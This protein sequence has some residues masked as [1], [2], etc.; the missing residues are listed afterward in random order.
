MPTEIE[1]ATYAADMKAQ[2]DT[3]AKRLLG[4][5]EILAR[6][7]INTIKEF[8]DM[9]PEDVAKLIE[10]EIAIGQVPADPGLTNAADTVSEEG[11][12]GQRI[13]GMNT[14]N[15]EI[16]EGL[17]RFD[18]I[19]Y[20]RMKDGVSQV[21]INVEIQKN[22][23]S[24]YD[25]LNRAIFY[26]CR[27]ISSQKERDFVNTN[28][29][30]I[31][32]VFSIWICMNTKE[33]SMNYIHLVNDTLLGSHEC[34]GNLDLINIILVSLAEELPSQD[35][36]LY[37]HRFLGTLLSDSLVPV[38]KLS[39][40]ETEFG[41]KTSS[42]EK[43]VNTMCNLSEGIEEKGIE[44]GIEKTIIAMHKKGYSVVQIAD[45]TE[46]SIDE[47]NSIIKDNNVTDSPDKSTEMNL[48]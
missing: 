40:L 21:I 15:A 48:F 45:I 25:I 46:K 26:V 29:D 31:K 30:D 19:F 41:V 33:N 42:I 38:E 20:V 6:I 24:E 16:N 37:L 10:D 47:I 4:N 39:I 17:I 1:N 34:G 27:L 9:E 3:A 22:I 44:K 11:K 23:P 13:V 28:Y 5:K 12:T 18:I 32:R 14:E 35:E 2:Y 8:C 36:G 43:G 7:L